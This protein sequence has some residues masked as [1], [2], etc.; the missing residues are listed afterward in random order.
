MRNPSPFKWRHFEA[1]IIR[2][3]VRWSLRYALSDRAVE[4]LLQE[5][6]VA[7]EHTTI[8]RWVQRDAL[9]LAQRCRPQLKATHDSHR[10]DETSRKIKKQWYLYRAVES[11]GNTIEFML[12]A[13]RE[14][15]AAKPFRRTR[16]C[17]RV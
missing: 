7:V 9:A 10:V 3:T 8:L 17:H 6:G 15:E 16:R 5:R 13:T 1:A 14:A 12:S 4:E 2:C 11:G